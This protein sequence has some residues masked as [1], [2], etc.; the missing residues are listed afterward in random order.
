M[1]LWHSKFAEA[2]EVMMT[3]GS[4]LGVPLDR[5]LCC[6]ELHVMASVDQRFYKPSICPETVLLYSSSKLE[7]HYQRGIMVETLFHSIAQEQE[8]G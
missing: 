2:E 6:P 4:T 7:F 3:G 8:S 1:V 5:S